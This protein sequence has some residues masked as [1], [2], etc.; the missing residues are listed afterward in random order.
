VPLRYIPNVSPT[1]FGALFSRTQNQR[2]TSDERR[3][4][5]STMGKKKSKTGKQKQVKK[6][7]KTFAKT[8]GFSEGKPEPMSLDGSNKKA[9]RATGRRSKTR[10][11]ESSNGK[12]SYSQQPEASSL[13]QKKQAVNLEQQELSRKKQAINR[14]QQELSRK[15]KAINQEQQELSR[16]NRPVNQEQQD[17]N[18]QQASM[19][20]RQ[21]AMQWKRNITKTKGVFQPLQLAP[22]S[23]AATDA[24]KSTEQ[25]VYETAQKVQVL[26]GIGY[27]GFPNPQQGGQSSLAA[28]AGVSS[29]WADPALNKADAAHV[30]TTNPWAVFG[31]DGDSDA[32]DSHL[33]QQSQL[34]PFSFAPP[35]FSFGNPTTS[36][37][38][39]DMDPDL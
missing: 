31:D 22:A 7:A 20:E 2:A 35:S 30:S 14:E 33:Q 39:S 12:D 24:D 25:L 11:L 21:H 34:R 18:R 17:F 23:F 26:G 29:L 13:S 28:A 9:R 32:G 27:T 37:M 1:I 36:A 16:K 8:L 19:L 4:A 3:A 15:K 5:S 6:L 10:L 38:S